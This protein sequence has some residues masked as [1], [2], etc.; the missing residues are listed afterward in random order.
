[1]KGIPGLEEERGRQGAADAAW[2]CG[3]NGDEEGPERRAREGH[4]ALGWRGGRGGIPQ[5]PEGHPGELRLAGRT[6]ISHRR[7]LGEGGP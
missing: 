7:V 2:F 6:K 1:M 5:S 3:R 4:G